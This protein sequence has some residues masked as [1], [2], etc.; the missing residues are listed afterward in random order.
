MSKIAIMSDLHFG[1]NKDSNKKLEALITSIDYFISR[2]KR[3]KITDVF[4]LGDW[5]HNR[6]VINVN[7]LHESVRVIEKLT[8]LFNVYMILGNHDLY[9]KNSTDVHSLS[10]LNL[11]Q[12]KSLC[13]HLHIIS[14]T[15][16]II[17]EDKKILCIP[18][19][20]KIDKDR[21]DYDLVLGHLDI[22]VNFYI[23]DF[24]QDKSP[25]QYDQNAIN[26]YLSDSEL[27]DATKCDAGEL[28]TKSLKTDEAKGFLTTY[29]NL[30]HDKGLVF[31]GHFHKH[32][33]I[34][35]QNKKFIF[36][37]SLIETTFADTNNDKGFYFLTLNKNE[38]ISAKF[39]KNP[40]GIKHVKISYS[41]MADSL[42]TV[43]K[44][45][46][47]KKFNII[48]IIVDTPESC[49]EIY[50]IVNQLLNIEHVVE[51]SVDFI[52]S[53]FSSM[54]VNADDS[55]LDSFKLS[56]HEYMMKFIDSIDITS[57]NDEI[58]I[59]LLKDR[60]AEYFNLS[61]NRL[62]EI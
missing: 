53:S 26:E 33:E 44:Q 40:L 3:N 37:G 41:E 42:E 20:G 48:K 27:Y 8:S 35:S 49:T 17:I 23:H 16:E 50:T 38:K 43:V 46:D 22:D 36:V 29:L 54:T 7:T 32:E 10:F 15:T 57:L 14:K 51:C 45:I 62:Y 12:G 6:N 11:L 30:I 24:I 47:I 34:K 18:W 52:N 60:A 59:K 4:F 61:N 28:P 5:F 25:E 55:N 21:N 1:I 13:N 9:L 2:C 56:K 39:V 31:S 58:D 19:L